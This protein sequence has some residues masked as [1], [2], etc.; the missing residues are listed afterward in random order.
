MQ[1]FLP[2]SDFYKSSQAL[3]RLRLGK[4]RIETWQLY[5]SLTNPSYG[6][7]NHPASKMWKGYE[8]ALLHYGVANCE[9]WI[10]R[11]YND[12]LLPR[13]KNALENHAGVPY[14]FPWWLG[15]EKLHSSHRSRLLAKKPDWYSQFGWTEPTN[16]PYWWPVK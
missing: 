2:Y 10:S 16:I 5:L 1:T 3:D 11:G 7:K 6:W 9:T 13:F 4:Q 8:I 15:N 14:E 12:S